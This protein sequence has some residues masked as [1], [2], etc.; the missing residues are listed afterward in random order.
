MKIAEA[1]D[2]VAEVTGSLL[3]PQIT[4]VPDSA[5]GSGAL[6]AIPDDV[7]GAVHEAVNDESGSAV[8]LDLSAQKSLRLAGGF[9]AIKVESSSSSD[10]FTLYVKGY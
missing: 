7:P 3:N 6:T 10:T 8:S 1:V 5:S 4:V 2:G 9:K